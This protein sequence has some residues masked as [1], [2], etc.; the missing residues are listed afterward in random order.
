MGKM[1]EV[2]IPSEPGSSP[3]RVEITN[4]EWAL[5]FVLLKIQELVRSSFPRMFSAQTES[6]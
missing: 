3:K 5:Q 1:R 4:L 2:E 6:M